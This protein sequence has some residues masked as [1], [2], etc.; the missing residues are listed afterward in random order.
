MC[1]CSPQCM[2]RSLS[3]KDWRLSDA[4]GDMSWPSKVGLCVSCSFSLPSFLVGD[5][6]G[7]GGVVVVGEG[8]WGAVCLVVICLVL[9]FYT[10][11]FHGYLRC[12]D[13][14]A[15]ASMN[16]CIEIILCVCVCTRESQC[17]HLES[18]VGGGGGGGFCPTSF[19]SISYFRTS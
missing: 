17:V 16:G 19:I 1:V 13:A 9:S 12:I 15:I 7:G 10:Q 4:C 18:G 5:V 6:V 8:A 2:A 3:L 14:C 11:N